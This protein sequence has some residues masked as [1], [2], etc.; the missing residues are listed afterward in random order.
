MVKCSVEGCGEEST[1]E[2]IEGRILHGEMVMVKVP[3]CDRHMGE[4][5]RRFF[6][7]EEEWIKANKQEE[8]H[9]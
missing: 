8:E 9:K 3:Y 6:E 7:L 4:K 2:N 5:L 1:S